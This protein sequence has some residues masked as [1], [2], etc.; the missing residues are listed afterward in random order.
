MGNYLK[1]DLTIKL[2]K[3]YEL[4]YTQKLVAEMTKFK[5]DYTE[6]IEELY[7]KETGKLESKKSKKVVK[8][9]SESNK[10]E[11]QVVL[12]EKEEVKLDLTYND[13]LNNSYG[14]NVKFSDFSL[15]PS[16]INAD[17]CHGI[18]KTLSG[19]VGAGF[20]TK[21]IIPDS[22]FVGIRIRTK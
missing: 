8:T 20:N 19:C 6:E 10:V 17:Y 7:N 5:Q 3:K 1:N 9:E 21:S 15:K 13:N 18:S 12:K 2:Q 11:K 14:L 22:G 16:G 4:E